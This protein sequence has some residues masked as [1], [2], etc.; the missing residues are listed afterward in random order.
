VHWGGAKPTSTAPHLEGEHRI[1]LE[2]AP[3]ERNGQLEAAGA[4]VAAGRWPQKR[5]GAGAVQPGRPGASGPSSGCRP[6]SSAAGRVV[7][8]PRKHNTA[9]LVQNLSLP[10]G[11]WYCRGAGALSSGLA[12]SAGVAG[13]ALCG[14]R[15][16]GGVG[17]GGVGGS[18][19]GACWQRVAGEGAQAVRP[20]PYLCGGRLQRVDRSRGGAAVAAG[21]QARGPRLSFRRGAECAR[22]GAP[23]DAQGLAL[24]L[25]HHRVYR[26][27]G[28][29]ARGFA[30]PPVAKGALLSLC[31][32]VY[33]TPRLATRP[34]T[35]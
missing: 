21:A 7:W 14:I 8:G 6:A 5:P 22:D 15:E 18:V 28:S 29:G 23:A 12:G 19:C 2:A 3:G 27:E 10:L 20:S 25:K 31:R 17:W 26:A 4:R 13:S 35:N 11:S 33:D 32:A 30:G 34:S 16:G 1:L 9:H 24:A